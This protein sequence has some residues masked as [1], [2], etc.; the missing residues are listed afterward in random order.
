MMR[1]VALLACLSCASA[2]QVQTRRQALQLGVVGAVTLTAPLAANAKSK[3]SILP[4]KP[5]GVGA[6]AGQY[7]SEVRGQSTC[8]THLDL[9]VSDTLP[10]LISPLARLA[11]HAAAKEGVCRDGGRQGFAWHCVRLV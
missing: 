4:N 6:N 11:F 5:E 9:R 1:L 2:F 7:L 10:C 3:A 8:P